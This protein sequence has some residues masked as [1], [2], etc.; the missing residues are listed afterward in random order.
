MRTGLVVVLVAAILGGGAARAE[1]RPERRRDATWGQIFGGRFSSSRLFA[2]PVAD[3]V[4]PYRLTLS[5]DG[6]LLQE[7]G[8]LSSAGVVALGFGDLAQLEYRHTTAISVGHTT[9]PVPAAGVQVKLPLPEGMYLPAVA[10]A[11]RLGV[12]RREHLAA[13]TV[14]EAVTDLYV[15]SRLHLWGWL[16]GVT[17]HAGVRVSQARIGIGGDQDFGTTKRLMVLPAAGFEIATNDR[18][19]LVGE[20]GFA[21]SFR[22]DPTAPRAPTIGSGLLGRLGVRWRIA[23]A[24]TLDG[25]I[26]YQLEVARMQPA[27]GLSAVVQWDIRL[28]AEVVVPWGAIACRTAGIFCE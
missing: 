13:T 1:P 17:V 8:I 10:I 11:F 22:Y 24:L 19:R 20:A 2:M 18:T 23:P 14:D 12:T 4:G 9:A 3:V 5:E 21:P 26:G 27:A 15:V 7:T 28:G 16:T 6:S 25:S